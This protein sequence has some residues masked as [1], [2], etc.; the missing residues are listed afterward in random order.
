[1][2][3]GVTL[4]QVMTE[5]RRNNRACP[6]PQAWQKLYEMLPGKRQV[7][8]GWEPPPPLTGSAWAA[9]QSLAKRMC[10]RDHIEWADKHGCLDAVYAYLRQLPEDDWH[11]ME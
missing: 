5:A 9:T 8:R 1:V 10:L 4:S 2:T 3:S 7:G 11:Y 6:Q